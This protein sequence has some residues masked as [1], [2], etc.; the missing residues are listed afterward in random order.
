MTFKDGE[1]HKLF[2]EVFAPPE[3]G[4]EAGPVST[5]SPEKGRKQRGQ[6]SRSDK[7][8]LGQMTGGGSAINK[9]ELNWSIYTVAELVRFRDE[10]TKAL[11]PLQLSHL[12]LEEEMLLQYHTLRELQGDVM[13]DG[14][15]P[16]NQRAQ[17]AN[18]VA[19]TLKSLGDM[20]VELYS[21]ERFKDIENL[22]VRTLDKM[23]EDL[24]AEFLTGY[25][26][27]LRKRGVE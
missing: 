21:S 5:F 9:R 15:V 24:A 7:I 2:P 4:G 22:L 10:I 8:A 6:P 11:P 27:M 16:V 1:G 14:E 12:N 3:E 26:E 13:G 23:P 25:E 18:S 19:S 17:V 20:Q